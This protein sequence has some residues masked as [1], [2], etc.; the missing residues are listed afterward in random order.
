LDRCRDASLHSVHE[1]GQGID[2]QHYVRGDIQLVACL[3]KQ[4][5]QTMHAGRHGQRNIADIFQYDAIAL[6][7]RGKR[8]FSDKKKPL[9]EQGLCRPT[10]GSLRIEDDC[11]IQATSVEHGIEMPGE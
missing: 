6:G 7:K 3:T 9:F 5:A 1:N 8:T 10:A 11:E 2:F 4:C